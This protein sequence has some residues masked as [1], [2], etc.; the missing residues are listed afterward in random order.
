MTEET[1]EP[2]RWWFLLKNLLKGRDLIQKS[3]QLLMFL[4]ASNLCWGAMVADQNTAG[5]GYQRVLWNQSISELKVIRLGL[6]KFGLGV[7]GSTTGVFLDNMSALAYLRKEGGMRSWKF[8][9]EA[10]RTLAWAEENNITLHLQFVKG[11]DNVVVD[12]LRGQTQ[13]YQHSGHIALHQ[14]VWW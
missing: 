11:I 9:Q 1:P 5:D 4:D 6:K 3:P 2:I 12:A 13:S 7:Q 10:Q 8:N 14:L